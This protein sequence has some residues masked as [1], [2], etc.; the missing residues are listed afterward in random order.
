M[1]VRIE[2]VIML[3]IIFIVYAEYLKFKANSKINWYNHGYK[4]AVSDVVNIYNN[5]AEENVTCFS[6]DILKFLLENGCKTKE[7]D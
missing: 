2:F 3:V 7:G 4:K 6:K 5:H 1:T